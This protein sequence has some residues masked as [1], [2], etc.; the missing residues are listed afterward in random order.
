MGIVFCFFFRTEHLVVVDE[1]YKTVI[2]YLNC[3]V[4]INFGLNLSLLEMKF[5]KSAFFDG[6]GGRDIREHLS[7]TTQQE[8]IKHCLFDYVIAQCRSNKERIGCCS[9][10]KMFIIFFYF[11]FFTKTELTSKTILCSL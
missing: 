10:P 6:W 9:E 3:L 1:I 11:Y 8:I 2:F 4:L 5:F 7:F